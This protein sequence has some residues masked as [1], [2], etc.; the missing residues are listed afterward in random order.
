MKS[1]KP[2]PIRLPGCEGFCLEIVLITLL[3]WAIVELISLI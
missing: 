3:F 1:N 2:R